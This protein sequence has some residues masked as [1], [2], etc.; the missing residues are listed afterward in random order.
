MRTTVL[1]ALVLIAGSAAA[2]LTPE[3]AISQAFSHR[4][5][6]RAARLKVRQAEANRAALGAI[7]PTRLEAGRGTFPDVGG[8]EDFLIA[9][10]V[11]IFGRAANGRDTGSA[12]LA[13][14][15]A[16]LRQTELDL[17]EEVLNA[18]ADLQSA[19]ALVQ[20]GQALADV[21]QKVYDATKRRVDQGDIPPAQLLRS[22]LDLER[23]K[24]TIEVRKRALVAARIRFAGSLGI[25]PDEVT[26]V[27][28][29]VPAV[30]ASPDIERRPDLQQIR[31]DVASARAD[32]RA[33]Q[34]SGL[35]DIEV[36]F[37]R[38]LWSQPEQYG[39]RVQLV[40]PLWDWG[41]ARN[42][43]RAARDAEKSALATLAD[44]RKIAR[45]EVDAAQADYDAAQTSVA[46]FERLSVEAKTLIDKEQR[47]FELGAS[48]LLNV[49]DATR[50][51][52]EIQESLVDARQRL[53]QSSAKLLTA[54]GTTLAPEEPT[55]SEKTVKK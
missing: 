36:Q 16:A 55:N 47:G 9:Q 35:P 17:Q 54:T 28:G 7:L 23:S 5:S 12:A 24:Q 6:V 2:Q 51:L 50:A 43:T 46:S 33:G 8:G 26:E 34:L 41:A 18:Y 44:R 13:S 42:R 15:H 37:R 14:A 52:R 48:T 27:E 3:A 11:D 29:G 31:S 20:T 53:M 19:Q 39:V 45:S 21:A 4:D 49:L 30:P 32:A 38:D 22:D 10:P 40:V 25:S 1:L